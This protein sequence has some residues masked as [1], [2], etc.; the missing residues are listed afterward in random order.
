[1]GLLETGHETEE[2]LDKLTWVPLE[3]DLP[4]MPFPNPRI[5]NPGIPE[6]SDPFFYGLTHIRFGIDY[7]NF[8]TRVESYRHEDR[9]WVWFA[10]QEG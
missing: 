6:L 10:L 5:P 1:M 4:T 9:V 8:I 3:S 7:P 2:R